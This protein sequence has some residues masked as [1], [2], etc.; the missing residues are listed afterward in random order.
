VKLIHDKMQ[1]SHQNDEARIKMLKESITK[2][3]EDFYSEKAERETFE[4]QKEKGLKQ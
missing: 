2:L 3:G 1:K 4:A